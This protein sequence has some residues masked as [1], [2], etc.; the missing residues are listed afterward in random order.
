MREADIMAT[1]VSREHA[2]QRPAETLRLSVAATAI[3]MHGVTPRTDPGTVASEMLRL[4][5][6]VRDGARA[7]LDYRAQPADFPAT[8]RAVADPVHALRF[9]ER[10]D[11]RRHGFGWHG[12][13][14]AAS[15]SPSANRFPFNSLASAAAALRR[16]ETTSV[17]LTRHALALA[18]HSAS[19]LNAFV[20]I[21]AEDA[22]AQAQRC[23]AEARAGH[24]R[25]PLHGIPLAHKDCFFREGQTMT[26]GARVTRAP[27]PGER[28]AHVLDRLDAAGAVSIGTLSLSEFVCGP[29][30]QNPGFGDCANAWDPNRISGGSSSGSGVAVAAGIIYGALGSDTG[31]STR[32]P[33]AL[34]GLYGIKPTYGLVSRAGSFPRAFSLDTIG[35][36]ARTAGDCALLLSEV[37]GHDPADPSSS[38]MPVPD[39]AALLCAPST[40]SARVGALLPVGGLDAEVQTAFDVFLRQVAQ[41]YALRRDIPF[42]TQETCYAMGDVLAKV[43]GATLHREWMSVQADR[44]SQAVFSR[45]EIGLHVPAARYL[46]ALSVRARLLRE[47]VEETMGDCDV[48]VCPTTPVTTPTREAADMEARD[49]VFGVVAALTRLTRAFNYLGVPVLNMPI[50]L[51]SHGMPI[52]VQLIGRPYGEARLFAMAAALAPALGW[53]HLAASAPTSPSAPPLTPLMP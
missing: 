43:E 15:F 47:F 22:L 14:D 11:D 28:T 7:H 8:L 38:A 30:G 1:E 12:E 31:G 37:A 23:D 32:L 20:E 51:D 10:T 17:A 25:G 29:T 40:R 35:P 52:G 4:N 36:L 33:A 18:R 53:P 50:G 21:R 42:A 27:L 6:Q 24:W 49:K 41:H 46:E 13:Y 16:G 26:V 39:Y 34:N 44:Y 5:A 19:R 9:D 2:M 3:A 48:L 45:T